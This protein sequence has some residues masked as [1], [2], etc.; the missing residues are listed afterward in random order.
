MYSIDKILPY[1]TIK[2][3]SFNLA[4]YLKDEV[5]VIALIENDEAIGVL[6]GV[7]QY[8][9]LMET[10]EI[11]AD[12]GTI[13]A[14]QRSHKDFKEGKTLSQDEVW[15]ESVNTPKNEEHDFFKSAGM[16][17]DRNITQE[18]LRKKAWKRN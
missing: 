4:E 18:S 1:A 6:M 5:D 14:L 15:K 2:Q 16:W 12:N 7:S 8:E 9:S 3:D 11:M 10:F 13:K 17:K